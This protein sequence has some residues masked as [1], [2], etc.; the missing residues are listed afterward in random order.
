MQITEPAEGGTTSQHLY[1]YSVREF[2]GADGKK[3]RAWTRIGVAFPHKDGTGFN[4]EVHSFPLD[5]HIV[6]FPAGDD[7]RDDEPAAAPP[8]QQSRNGN[9]RRR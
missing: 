3:A 9:P 2:D 8:P 7:A 4:V 5:G 1:A 6:L